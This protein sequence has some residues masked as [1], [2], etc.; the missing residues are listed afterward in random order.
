MLRRISAVQLP[1]DQAV[2]TSATASIARRSYATAQASGSKKK[3]SES[4]SKGSRSM[5]PGDSRNEIIKKVLYES[6]P[7]QEA[8]VSALEKVVPSLE[9]HETITRAWQLHRR[10][11]RSAHSLELARKYE[12]MRKAIDLL[13]KTDKGLWEMAVEGKKFQNV[14][15]RDVGNE[16]LD[17][18]WPRELRVP[19]EK[20]AEVAWDE[21]WKAPVTEVKE[22]KAKK[23]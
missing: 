12:S 3:A 20:G 18:I 7:T 16:R 1:L 10:S 15:Q 19:M 13:E 8:R 4:K 6:E 5:E 2:G 23:M 9:V 14:A 21:E 17:G 22:E 11:Q